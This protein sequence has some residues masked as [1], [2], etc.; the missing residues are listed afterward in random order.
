[1]RVTITGAFPGPTT[2]Q[3][4]ANRG[5]EGLLRDAAFDV[6]RLET[7]RGSGNIRAWNYAIKVKRLLV[8][9]AAATLDRSQP[10]VISLDRRWG[11]SLQAVMLLTSSRERRVLLVHHT[12]DGA[13]PGIF[14]AAALRA[15]RCHLGV[16]ALCQL[17]RE[18]ILRHL[19]GTRPPE[20]AAVMSN[21]AWVSHLKPPPEG[22]K[23]PSQENLRVLHFA[24]L[25]REKGLDTVLEVARLAKAAHSPIEV[26]IGG[27]CKSH[28]LRQELERA[29]AEGIVR[30]VGPIDENQRLAFMQEFDVLLFPTRYPGETEPLVVIE[31]GILGLRVLASKLGC[32]PEMTAV[33]SALEPDSQPSRWLEA[34]QRLP[35]EEAPKES[36]AGV[37]PSEVAQWLAG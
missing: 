37:L 17:H 7:Q 22:V 15:S 10:L 21:T 33:T 16:L 29:V 36:P 12:W 20:L 9:L 13:R 32:I 35:N 6:R 11:R 8:A 31:A 23:A 3:T 25:T 26:T 28:T 5:L 2:G 1:M 14:L 27:P 18:M 19:T 24:N 4:L 34:I 30:Y